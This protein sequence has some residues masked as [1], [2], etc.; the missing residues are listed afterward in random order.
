MDAVKLEGGRAYAA[1]VRTIVRAGIPVMGHIGL[2]PQSVNALGGWRVQ[3][4][5]A[6]EAHGLLEDALA[7]QDAGCFSIVLE[8][9]PERLAAYITER[10][11]V[12]TIGIGAGPGTSGQVLVAH[13]VLGL[14]D[15]F[16]PK[17]VKRYAELGEAMTQAF[18]TYRAE[19]QERV[20]PGPEHSYSLPDEEWE[21]FLV[22][23]AEPA[24]VPVKAH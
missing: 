23:V 21:A 9:V 7:L 1:T 4:R 10:L 8:S 24:A 16:T 12:P 5:T 20:F 15:R 22:T 17:F 6:D 3:G 11:G 19:V 18:A 13:D 14:F 2:T